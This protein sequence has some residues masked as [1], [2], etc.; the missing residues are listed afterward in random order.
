MDK[1][2][3]YDS[4]PQYDR[5][6]QLKSKKFKTQPSWIIISGNFIKKHSTRVVFYLL[7]FI[8]L[9]IFMY[10]DYRDRNDYDYGLHYIFLGEN[11]GRFFYDNNSFFR[12]FTTIPLTFLFIFFREFYFRKK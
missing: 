8:S 5:R 2:K 9:N 12:H 3:S 6:P 11:N 10:S 4:G 7:L 1:Q